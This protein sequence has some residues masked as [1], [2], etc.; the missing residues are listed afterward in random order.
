M[1]HLQFGVEGELNRYAGQLEKGKVNLRQIKPEISL[2]AKMT[3][4]K[5]SYFGHLMGRQA[6]LEK[7]IEGN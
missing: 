2:D 4:L 1:I 5:M 6:P 7:A 3:K